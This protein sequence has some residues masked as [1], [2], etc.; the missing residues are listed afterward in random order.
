MSKYA[1]LAL[2]LGLAAPVVNA[3][4][5]EIDA[6][7]SSIGFSVRHMIVSTVRGSF[8]EF[9]GSFEYDAAKPAD[10]KASAVIKTASIDTRNAKRDDHLRNED[11][12]DAPKFPDIT[13]ETTRVEADGGTLTLFGNLT[14]KGVTKEIALPVTFHGPI[15]DPWGNVRAGFEGSTTINR[16]DWGISWSKNLDGG[17]LVVSDEVKL[18][19]SIE[20]IKK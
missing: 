6:S 5:Y 1:V 10:T 2:A 3:G 11:F 12:F 4:T 18:E 16:Q 19:I 7:H 20:G 14:M 15:T 8:G 13:F 17:G 9:T